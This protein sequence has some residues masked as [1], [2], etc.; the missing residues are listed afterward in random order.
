MILLM[1][2]IRLTT[3]D[4][5]NLV[6]NGIKLP[7]NWCRIFSINSI[8]LNSPLDIHLSSHFAGSSSSILSCVYQIV[9]KSL[10]LEP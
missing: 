5:K 1:E 10:T 8:D 6:N 9:L 2:E 3:W 4:V 7:I